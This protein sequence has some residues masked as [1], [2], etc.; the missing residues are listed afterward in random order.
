MLPYRNGASRSGS[1]VSAEHEGQPNYGGYYGAADNN[2]LMQ[3]TTDVSQA[4]SN[5]TSF[6]NHED[7]PLGPGETSS[8]A[9]SSGHDSARLYAHEQSSAVNSASTASSFQNQFRE[10]GPGTPSEPT[11]RRAFL[12]VAPGA[13]YGGL[14]PRSGL[15]PL[16]ESTSISVN[17]ADYKIGG[18]YPDMSVFLNRPEDDDWLHEVRNAKDLR[19]SYMMC[20]CR[21][22]L[23]IGFLIVLAIA[24]L[25][26]FAGWPVLTYVNTLTGHALWGSKGPTI[27]SQGP[28]WINVLDANGKPRRM[29]KSPLRGLIDQDTPAS[30]M[31]KMS[32]DGKRKMKLVFSDEFNEDGRTFFEG[33][34]PY[35]T[36]VDLH[37]WGTNDFEWYSPLGATTKDGALKISLT[38]QPINNLNFKSAMLQSWNKL[39][40]QGGYLEVSL[41]L[42]GD[43]K[44]AGYWP[45]A[46]MMAN[47][48]RAGYG[49]TN[50]GMWPYNY[51]SCDVGTM[52]NQ[53][54]LANGTGGPLAAEVTGAYVESYGPAL[55][56]QPG[57]KLSRCTCASST[58]HPGPK[59]EDGTWMG[60]GASE[61][62]LLEATSGGFGR[63]SMSLQTAPFNSG[64]NITKGYTKVYD[65]D[66]SLN[67]Y[68]G[69]AYQQAVSAMIGTTQ[70]AYVTVSFLLDFTISDIQASLFSY[71]H[72]GGHYGLYGVEWVPHYRN[73][74]PY[75]TWMTEGQPSW[76]LEAGAL[77]PD[78]L[79]EI[80]QRLVPPEPMY[81]IFNLGMSRGFSPVDFDKIQFPGVMSVDYVRVYQDEDKEALSCDGKYPEMPSVS[82]ITKHAEA[83]W[84]SNLTIWR[85][86]RENGAYGKVFPGHAMKGECS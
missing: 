33:D 73:L 1:P 69:A 75:I 70:T 24:L 16:S 51:D 43:P 25:S 81:I 29:T 55:S 3:S 58:D 40:I 63:N 32:S 80:G 11:Q 49:A 54:Y 59:H 84:N 52:P 4:S 76:T 62:D 5:A 27:V 65:S 47:I 10:I 7:H 39:C 26:L 46:W 85:G 57:Q 48:G 50:E 45:A 12:N 74:D 6:G 19:V 30:A 14:G 71:Q 31:T 35:W 82:Y 28:T 21:G 15:R 22:L 79:T 13:G 20:T 60:R 23:N 42:P 17:G 68:T 66:N 64:Y 41:T 8:H 36:A 78:K 9:T 2:G 83:Y 56:Y 37:Y 67:S 53:T 18:H 34:D 61:L 44:V 72:S 77:G 38:E 86:K